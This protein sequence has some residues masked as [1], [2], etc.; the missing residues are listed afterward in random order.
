MFFLAELDTLTCHLT[1]DVRQVEEIRQYLLLT[2]IISR[3]HT[4]LHS[5]LP[6]PCFNYCGTNMQ[7]WVSCLMARPLNI[8][9]QCTT[10]MK[11]EHGMRN[12]GNWQL[13]AALRAVFCLMVCGCVCVCVCTGRREHDLMWPLSLVR[14]SFRA[15]QNS[16]SPSLD[17]S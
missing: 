11:Y 5:S 3:K 4:T 15:E 1:G 16:T 10:N 8:F 12:R 13:S 14:I 6:D 7:H 9:S 2:L 17:S